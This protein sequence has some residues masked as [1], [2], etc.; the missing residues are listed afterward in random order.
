M[1]SFKQDIT[2]IAAVCGNQSFN[3][4]IRPAAEIGVEA[5]KMTGI[6]Y[7]RGNMKHNGTVI[8]STNPWAGLQECVISTTIM[9]TNSSNSV[10]LEV[11]KEA[12]QVLLTLW[13]C[14]WKTSS[15]Q[16]Q[17]TYAH[18]TYECKQETLVEPSLENNM[19]H[20]ML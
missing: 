19:E 12:C 1:F 10:Y 14:P 13:K 17:E 20:T 3:P 6:T 5:L 16:K 11:F 18:M 9:Y 8:K 4:Y 7:V 2:Q 15:N